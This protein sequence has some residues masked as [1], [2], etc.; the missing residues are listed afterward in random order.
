MIALLMLAK[1]GRRT[2]RRSYSESALILNCWS[3]L[4]VLFGQFRSA[5]P[6]SLN[7]QDRPGILLKIMLSS[8][9]DQL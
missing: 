5:K 8:V 9:A 4:R 7:F 1:I 3:L 6:E 2:G